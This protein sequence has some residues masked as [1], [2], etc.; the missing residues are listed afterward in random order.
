MRTTTTHIYTSTKYIQEQNSSSLALLQHKI[1]LSLPSM[2]LVH[3]HHHCA[4]ENSKDR[5]D[6]AHVANSELLRCPRAESSSSSSQRSL[7]EGEER[8][9]WLRSQLVGSDVEF[10]TPFAGR[11]RLVYADHTA[12]GRCLHYIENYIIQHVLPIYGTY[13][14]V[15]LQRSIYI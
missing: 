6:Y 3:D 8:I 10:E 12:S 14:T 1:M 4:E 11:R 15:L 5:E 7:R 2:D 9:A 13:P